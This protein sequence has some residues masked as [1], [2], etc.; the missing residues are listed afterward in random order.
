MTRAITLRI[1]EEIHRQLEE[2]AVRHGTTITHEATLA[3]ELLLGKGKEQ[4][5]A[6]AEVVARAKFSQE[7]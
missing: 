5:V 7:E 6:A 1:S 2:Q 4:L 3:L